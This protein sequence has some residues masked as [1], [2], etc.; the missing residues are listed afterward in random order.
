MEAAYRIPGIWGEEARF[1]I[2]SPTVVCSFEGLF[3]NSCN[4]PLESF[5]VSCSNPDVNILLYMYK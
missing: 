1:I 5:L 2:I 4:A 3:S